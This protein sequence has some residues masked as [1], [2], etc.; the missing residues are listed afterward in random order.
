MRS[1]EVS[2][3]ETEPTSAI[4]EALT[5]ILNHPVLGENVRNQVPNIE[6]FIVVPCDHPS[7]KRNYYGLTV[8][9]P[10]KGITVVFANW[11]DTPAP[12]GQVRTT[13]DYV[14]TIVHEFRHV[15]QYEQAGPLMMRIIDREVIELDALKAG[16]SARNTYLRS[17]GRAPEVAT[18]TFTPPPAS[19][20]ASTN[21]GSPQG[22][23]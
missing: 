3:Y 17:Q 19:A 16:R 10:F 9:D 6:H 23:A 22:Q 20:L 18:I 1:L 13:V 12:N 4:N 2:Y 5:F 11:G 21:G 7:C 15:Y 8:F 14:E